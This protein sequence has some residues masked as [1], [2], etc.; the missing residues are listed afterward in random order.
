MPRRRRWRSCGQK[1]ALFARSA[2]GRPGARI[3]RLVTP[4]ERCGSSVVPGA[5]A[6]CAFRP[7]RISGP[8]PIAFAKRSSTGSQPACRAPAASTCSRAVAPSASRRCPAAPRALTFVE[9]RPDRR[10]CDRGPPRRMGR[11]GRAG[12][13]C[14]CPA[15][16]RSQGRRAFRHRIPR[17]RPSP[18]HSSTATAGRLEQGG[19]LAPNAVI[20]IECPAAR[21]PQDA[22]PRGW[23]SLKSKR[24][25]EVGYHL[26]S[27]A[28]RGTIIE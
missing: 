4:P 7:R 23:T 2:L 3:Q 25:G 13:K 1:T 19:W 24:A 11:A 5:G 27:R 6:V 14:R 26:Y 22:L 18:R 9:Q 10:E 20:Y 15:L 28:E 21:D 8:P 17:S 16:S 12:R